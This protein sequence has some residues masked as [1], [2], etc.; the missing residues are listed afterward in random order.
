M[1]LTLTSLLSVRI[2]VTLLI[3]YV[4]NGTQN[5][6]QVFPLLLEVCQKL[7]PKI[8]Y[9]HSA[10]ILTRQLCTSQYHG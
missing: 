4:L 5:H 2:L 7:R 1:I 6:G 8:L 9:N 3:S 10:W